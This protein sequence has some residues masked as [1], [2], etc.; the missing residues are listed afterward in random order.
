MSMSRNKKQNSRQD[1]R[2]L[3][4]KTFRKRDKR[5]FIKIKSRITRNN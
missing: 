5:V 3:S 2:E 1:E 4:L